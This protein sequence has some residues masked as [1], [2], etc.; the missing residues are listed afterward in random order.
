MCVIILSGLMKCVSGSQ[1]SVN[2]SSSDSSYQRYLHNDQQPVTEVL[3][4]S[5]HEGTF[6]D[7]QF[8]IDKLNSQHNESSVM[9]NATTSL[10]VKKLTRILPSDFHKDF[11]LNV[12]TAQEYLISQKNSKGV[13]Y[14]S[15]FENMLNKY[16]LIVVGDTIPD[17]LHFL[18]LLNETLTCELNPPSNNGCTRYK[19]KVI[20]QI[21]NRFNFRMN[22][23]PEEQL[24]YAHL[25]MSLEDHRFIHF[26]MNNPYEKLCLENYH[27]YIKDIKLIRPFGVSYGI[28]KVELTAEQKSHCVYMYRSESDVTRIKP[29]MLAS[30]ITD[31][32]LTPLS[33]KYGG[34]DTLAE[35]KVR[36]LL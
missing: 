31:D 21:T 1:V 32:I 5:R 24:V 16:D 27:A 28:P 18:L 17:S 20:L 6:N 26:V 36:L 34:P 33:L 13:S 9:T 15:L 19:S 25:L 11:G 10:R 4:Y 22:E 8:L 29:S 7:F 35:Y 30:G 12:K 3:Y 23:T 14:R 2:S